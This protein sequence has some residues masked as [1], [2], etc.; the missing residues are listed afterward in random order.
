MLVA[1]SVAVT[2]AQSDRR[3]PTHMIRFEHSEI[4]AWSPLQG[5]AQALKVGHTDRVHGGGI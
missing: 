5:K 2:V 4:H 3:S 1:V